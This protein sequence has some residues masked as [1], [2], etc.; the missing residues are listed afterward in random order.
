MQRS[1]QGTG[2]GRTKIKTLGRAQRSLISSKELSKYRLH[3]CRV[4]LSMLT[5]LGR[6][7][8]ESDLINSLK[9]RGEREEEG[10]R[11]LGK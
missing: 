11:R 1:N 2:E 6:C 9:K 7:I 4:L 10:T 5:K 3:L 8:E